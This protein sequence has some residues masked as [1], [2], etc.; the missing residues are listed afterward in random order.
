[1]KFAWLTKQIIQVSKAIEEAWEYVS[2]W[3]DP[4][5]RFSRD[6]VDKMDPFDIDH[7]I[8]VIA[9]GTPLRFTSPQGSLRSGSGLVT[10]E[11]LTYI[12]LRLVDPIVDLKLVEGRPWVLIRHEQHRHR[13]VFLTTA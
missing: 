10:L 3:E 2:S 6:C 13:L 12:P 1:M 11:S 4:V 5:S 7:S 8:Q 9:S